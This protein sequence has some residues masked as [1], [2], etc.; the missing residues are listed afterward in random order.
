[1]VLCSDRKVALVNIHTKPTDAVKEIDALTDVH[2]WI[3][4]SLRIKV[5]ILGFAVTIIN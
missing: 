2:A 1:M 5:E 4:K 3:E